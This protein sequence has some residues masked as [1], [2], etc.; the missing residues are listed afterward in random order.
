[1][2]NRKFQNNSIIAKKNEVMRFFLELANEGSKDA[3]AKSSRNQEN[4]TKALM[5]SILQSNQFA[6]FGGVSDAK[7]EQKKLQE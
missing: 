1:M 5:S 4:I 6:D 2:L 7:K 3:D